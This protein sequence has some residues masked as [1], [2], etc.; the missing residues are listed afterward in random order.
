MIE[1]GAIQNLSRRVGAGVMVNSQQSSY[2]RTQL[3]EASNNR[4]IRIRGHSES[5][6]KGFSLLGK[7]ITQL[8]DILPIWLNRLAIML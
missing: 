7:H 8:K 6:M 5:K 1:G 4:L 2:Q 3:T